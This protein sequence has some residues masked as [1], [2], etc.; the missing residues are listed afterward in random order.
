MILLYCT[1][2]LTGLGIM[3]AV[4]VVRRRLADQTGREPGTERPNSMAAGSVS[5]AAGR[6]RSGCC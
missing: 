3:Y 1:L 5:S 4:D 6:R 2:M